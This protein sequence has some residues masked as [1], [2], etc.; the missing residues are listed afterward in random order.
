MSEKFHF[1]PRYNPPSPNY[2]IISS[3]PLFLIQKIKN[4]AFIVFAETINT[5]NVVG[6]LKHWSL[7]VFSMLLPTE[8]A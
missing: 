1:F 6:W 3:P 4:I 7:L 5:E 2:Q 8:E